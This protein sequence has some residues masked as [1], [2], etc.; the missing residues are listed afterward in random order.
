VTIIGQSKGTSL[1]NVF[2]SL[3]L[4]ARA[5]SLKQLL[6]LFSDEKRSS[7]YLVSA[8]ILMA[9]VRQVD[10][11]SCCVL[12]L[13]VFCNRIHRLMRSWDIS[14][15]RATQKAQ[16]TRLCGRMIA[17]FQSMVKEKIRMM[18]VTLSNVYNVDQTNCYY[19]I[20]ARF[21]LAKKGSKTVSVKGADLSNLC[22]IMLGA[23][24][25]GE[26]LL[27]YIVFKEMIGGRIS[28]EISQQQK[29]GYPDDVVLAI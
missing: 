6:H 4:A 15:R 7:D 14:W 16:K 29:E 17:D 24:A 9:E 3:V 2:G 8:Q 18:S 11:V 27:Q 12:I 22:T 13:D 5:A 19:S 23:S 21:T 20:E 10:L 26:K 28:Q 1:Q 25:S